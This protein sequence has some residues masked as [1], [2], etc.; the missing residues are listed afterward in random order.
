[1]DAGLVLPGGDTLQLL[2]DYVWL[3]RNCDG[4][5]DETESGL[6]GVTV[7]LYSAGDLVVPIATTV[8]G[9]GGA[10]SFDSVTT[11][12]LVPGS[13]VVQ[14]VL[15]NGYTFTTPN[16]TADGSDSDAGAGGY[17][18]TVV[19]GADDSDDTI[20]AG[21]CYF[22]N[23]GTG[24]PGYWKTHPEAWPVTTI[25]IGGVL[26]TRE[27]AIALMQQ[28][29]A[30]NKWLNMFEQLVAAKLNVMIG[31]DSTCIASTIAAA[32]TWMAADADRF[33]RASDATWT[34]PGSG[35]HTTLDQYNNGLLCAPH[36]D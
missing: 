17:S 3:D 23:P 9:P 18:H 13:Y 28:S 36:R 19:L 29:T 30:R 21:L 14:F 15:P 24:T 22:E 11:P 16:A 10:Y 33:V 27:A 20:D 7:N 25:S 26:Y 31:N 34:S 5:Q 1:L 4:V 8:T 2:G 32:D 12:D 6:E 35:L